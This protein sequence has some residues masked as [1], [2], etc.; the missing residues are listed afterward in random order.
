MEGLKGVELLSEIKK[1]DPYLPVIIMTAFGKVDD[2]VVSIKRGAFSYIEKP[3]DPD[4]LEEM[5]TKAIEIRELEKQIDMER[6]L[7]SRIISQIGAGLLIVTIEGDILWANS[8]ACRLLGRSGTV[9]NTR[10]PFDM[11]LIVPAVIN[12]RTTTTEYFDENLKTWFLLSAARREETGDKAEIAVL[13]LDITEL[14]EAQKAVKV[15]TFSIERIDSENIEGRWVFGFFVSFQHLHP[16]LLLSLRILFGFG[17]RID[18]IGYNTGFQAIRYDT[19]INDHQYHYRFVND[20]LLNGW[21]N[22]YFYS[23]TAFDKGNPANNLPSLESSILENRTYVVPGALPNKHAQRKVSVYP[24]PY[25]AQALWDGTGDRDRMLWFT[26]L[27]E[28]AM[29]R[30]FNLAGDLVNSF[31][32]DAAAYNGSG[33]RLLENSQSNAAVV[34][35][36]GEHAWDLI[37]DDDQAI[38]TGLYLFAVK[39]NVTGNIKRGK[40]LVIK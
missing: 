6:E 31:E 14:K 17:D 16:L 27:P 39:D 26:N 40:F 30:I 11:G 19:T 21:P 24:N 29:V 35:S 32:H 22:K 20:L 13:I 12:E 10:V 28:K 23:V 36:G 15:Q 9:S 37:T 25:R 2:A 34:F 38:A 18:E 8:S 3:I 7:W 33:A 5:I 1:L 4:D